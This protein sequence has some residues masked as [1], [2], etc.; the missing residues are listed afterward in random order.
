MFHHPSRYVEFHVPVID[1]VRVFM[2]NLVRYINY[3]NVQLCL[4]EMF[5]SA[6]PPSVTR[7][8]PVTPPDHV[9]S[10]PF[11]QVIQEHQSANSTS[12]QSYSYVNSYESFQVTNNPKF[13]A[14]RFP[15]VVTPCA[16]FT[17]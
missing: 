2:L 16:I 4:V 9:I 6:Q 17:A 12:N 15:T 8:P 5:F 11:Q 10:Y 1:R 3:E 13:I 14:C 7:V